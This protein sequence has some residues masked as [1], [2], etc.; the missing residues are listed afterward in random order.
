[1]KPATRWLDKWAVLAV[2]L[3]TCGDVHVSFAAEQPNFIVINIDDLGYAD[4]GPF[5]SKLNRTPYLDRM[6]DEGRKLTCFYAAPVCSPSRAA[7]MT[8]C[9]PKRALSIP[10]VLFPANDVGLDPGEVTVAELLKQQ[11]YVTAIVGKWHL[12]DQPEF[13]PTRQGFDYYY[14][15]P[16]SNDMGPVEDGVKSS[17]GA[18]LPKPKPNAKG[19]PPLPLMRNETVLQRVLPEDQTKLVTRYTREAVKFLRANRDRPFFLYLPHSAVH[20]PL[21]PG[22]A[23]QGRSK[24]GLYGDWVEEVDGS[25]GQVLD[26]VRELDLANKTLVLFTS[27]NGGSLRFGAVNEPLRGGKGSTWEGGMRVP[28]IAWWPG[29]IPAGTESDVVAGM[30]D[31]LPTL[32]RLAGGS[33]PQDRTIDGR[34]LWPVL[35]GQPHAQPPHDVFYF[36]RGLELQAVRQGPWKLQLEKSQLYNLETD[37]GE[38]HDVSQQQ[39]EVVAQLRDLAALMEKDL[40]VKGIG[41]GCRPLGKVE[42]AQPLIDYSGQPRAGFEPDRSQPRAA[43]GGMVGEVTSDSALVQV[44]LT[45]VDASVDGDVPGAPGIVRFDLQL[46]DSNARDSTGS[47]SQSKTARAAAERDFISRVSFHNLLPGEAYVCRTMIGSDDDVLVPGPVLRFKTHPGG[48]DNSPTRFVVVTG[49]NYAKFHGD[50][51]I[52]RAQHVEQNNTELPPA[53]EGIDKELG[54]PALETIRKLKPDFFVATGDNVYYDTPIRSRA[55]TLEECRQKWHEQFVQPRYV[56]LFAEVPTYWEFDDHDYRVDDC[57]N[58]GDYAPSP[59]LGQR[60]I[61][62]QLPIAPAAEDQAILYRTHRVS[63]DLQI[64]LCENRLSRSPNRTPDG[65]DKTIWGAEQKAWLQHTLLESDAR[66]KLLISPTPMIG[67]DDLRKKDNHSNVGG[68]RHERDEFFAWL[69]EHGITEQNFFIICGDRH[70]Q[71]HSIH[72]S[73]VEELS[74]GALVDANSRLGR[75]PGDPKST[76]PEAQI[77]QPYCQQSASGGF[78]MV[79][80][81][82]SAVSA[83]S[84]LTFNFHD[85]NGQLLHEHRVESP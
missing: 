18:P 9:Y 5:G 59:A 45:A 57:D 74:C 26:A 22:K 2:C 28:T 42:D 76:D 73:G 66:F 24:N 27:D 78:L 12:G 85:E 71:Y 49:M 35:A 38:S 60:L 69:K 10:H 32:V 39:E 55:K 20:F 6:A 33:L 13:L 19:Q 1:M 17:L 75:K 72:P 82:P 7:L 56:D 83:P 46:A 65:P 40:G 36:Y 53:F 31:I 14:G 77:E 62:E 3:V 54:Y 61:R 67:P 11:G 50:K 47:D 8:G 43:M 41:P 64:W 70:W 37:I 21:Y 30:I 58:T 79:E 16:Y 25:V 29:R 15:L 51:R 34:D 23:F 4:I 81:V 63:R 48:N 80:S 44:R 68:F 84:T 52:D